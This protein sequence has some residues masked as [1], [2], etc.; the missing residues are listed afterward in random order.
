MGKAPFSQR[1]GAMVQNWEHSPS[2]VLVAASNA[3]PHEVDDIAL[4]YI[5]DGYE[6][7][8]VRLDAEYENKRSKNL[9]KWKEMQDEEFPIIDIQ[10]GDGNR[11]GMAARVILALPDGRTFAAGMIG[12]V[13]F[14]RQFLIEKSLH[15]GKMGTVVFQ[16]YTPDGVPRFPKFKAVRD[17]E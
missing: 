14:C 6:G 11:A 15:I 3:A 17:Y 7:A 10:E 1:Y 13:A 2:L 12:N 8:M 9:I 5:E 16:N 4:K